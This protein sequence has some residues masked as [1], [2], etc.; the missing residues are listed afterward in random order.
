MPRNTDKNSKAADLGKRVMNQKSL[1]REFIK[2][3]IKKSPSDER[4]IE[5]KLGDKTYLVRELG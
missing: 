5:V 3:L 2:Q 1:G 4:S